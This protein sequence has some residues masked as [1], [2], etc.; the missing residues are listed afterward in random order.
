MPDIVIPDGVVTKDSAYVTAI[1]KDYPM[2]F[3]TFNF[4]IALHKIDKTGAIAWKYTFYSPYYDS[5]DLVNLFTAQNGDIIGVGMADFPQ[6]DP[7]FTKSAGWIFRVSLDGKLLWQRQIVDLTTPIIGSYLYNGVE[8]DNGDLLFTG[9]QFNNTDTDIWLLKTDSKGCT[10]TCDN[11]QLIK[12]K[13]A[14]IEDRQNMFNVY[15]N[16]FVSS[17]SYAI[18]DELY[19]QFANLNIKITN[20]LGETMLQTKI[21]DAKGSI[22]LS[23]MASGFYNFQLINIEKSNIIISKKIIKI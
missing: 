13:E 8:L 18:E 9:Y 10:I 1:R 5:R 21:I 23:T 14:I 3:D 4:P 6:D 16:P 12:T 22:D 20:I 11:N 19:A 15:P 17:L 7:K 2:N